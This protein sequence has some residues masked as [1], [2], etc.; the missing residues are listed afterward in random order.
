MGKSLKNFVQEILLKSSHTVNTLVIQNPNHLNFKIFP[1]ILNVF[2]KF[3]FYP[4][5][6]KSIFG[7]R[8]KNE[9]TELSRCEDV[10][11]WLGERHHFTVVGQTLSHISCRC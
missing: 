7:F 4:K 1:N 2:S 10:V 8:Y 11:E 5:R 3:S 9:Q 6:C